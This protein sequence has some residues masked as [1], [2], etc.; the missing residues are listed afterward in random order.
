[1]IFLE[2]SMSNDQ[3]NPFFKD[4]KLFNFAWLIKALQPSGCQ[5]TLWRMPPC[6]GSSI[7]AHCSLDLQPISGEKLMIGNFLATRAASADPVPAFSTGAL[8]D[9]VSD[10]MCPLR[11]WKW[12]L[13]A[14]LHQSYRQEGNHQYHQGCKKHS[15]SWW[16]AL[17]VRKWWTYNSLVDLKEKKRDC[18]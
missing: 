3:E 1:M 8:K 15:S 16:Q 17:A 18:M 7:G 10:P 13:Q 9:L 4:T 12:M 2:Y 5:G 11:P 14:I 6:R